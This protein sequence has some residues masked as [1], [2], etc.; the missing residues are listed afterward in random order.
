MPLKTNIGVSR[1]IADNSYGSRGA[2]VNLEVELDSTFINEPERFHDRIRQV[3]R[4]PSRLSTKNCPGSSLSARRTTRRM[5]PPTAMLP[6]HRR[7]ATS[8]AQRYEWQWQPPDREYGHRRNNSP[9][10]ANS[11]SRSMVSE[12]VAWK[13][14]PRKCSASPLWGS[15]HSTLRVD[16]LR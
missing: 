16:R 10:P 3:F 12:S 2:S 5:V 15:P 7:M 4:W 1:K 6:S 9:T 14:S 11:P 13:I 8:N